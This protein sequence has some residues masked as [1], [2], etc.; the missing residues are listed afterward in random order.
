MGDTPSGIDWVQLRKDMD[1]TGGAY[2]S[3]L[4]RIFRKCGENPLVPFGAA[5]TTG[6][7]TYGLISFYRGKV[8]MQQNM[9]RLRVGAQAFTILV[10]VGGI[11]LTLPKEKRTFKDF[12]EAG[13]KKH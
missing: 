11:F 9:M 13:E 12:V 7:L 10:A 1:A 4:D 2:E 8:K 6:A 5:A 3:N